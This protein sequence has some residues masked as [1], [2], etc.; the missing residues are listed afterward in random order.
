MF[1]KS[2]NIPTGSGRK[3]NAIINLDD[4]RSIVQIKNE[5]TICLVR[6]IVVAISYHKNILQEVFKDKLI[7][8]EIKEINF[9]KQSL[10]Q[11]N[12]DVFSDTELK[13]LRQGGEK[14][15]QTVLAEAFHRIHNIPIKEA[16]NDFLDLKLIEEKLGHE[17]QVYNMETRKIY[18]GLEKPVKI[19]LILSKNH[20]DVISK[21]PAF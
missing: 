5:D 10:T 8:E 18:A 1:F 16:S 2:I 15:L 20:F 11:I 4:E 7:M 3:C 13:Y 6:S 17:I 21:L 14:K 12:E 19:Y 9:R